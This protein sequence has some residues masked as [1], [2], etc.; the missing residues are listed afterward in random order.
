[1]NL[2]EKK[3]GK[4]EECPIKCHQIGAGSFI[5]MLTFPNVFNL[6]PFM[7]CSL[8]TPYMCQVALVSSFQL[9]FGGLDYD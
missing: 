1:M 2:C 4:R 8:L 3:Y 7:L 9:D 5:R 6:L